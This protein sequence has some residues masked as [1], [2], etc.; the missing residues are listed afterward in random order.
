MQE[1]RAWARLGDQRA[2]EQALLRGTSA[3]ERLPEPKHPDH[4]FVFD[5]DKFAYYAAT[6]YAWLGM[7]KRTE[8]YALQVIEANRD[9]R[10][11]NF[12]PGRVRG[13]LLDL[14]L[15]LAKQGRPD[16]AGHDW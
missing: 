4:H 12:W 3:L 9:P 13:A 11:P 15:V 7:A 10:R 1:A 8:N 2:A 16:E 6:T 14:G 5:T